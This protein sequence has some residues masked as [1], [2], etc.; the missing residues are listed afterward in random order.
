MP[1]NTRLG[2]RL[3][4]SFETPGSFIAAVSISSASVS[5][6]CDWSTLACG[7]A[8]HTS[9][10]KCEAE[11]R[12][13]PVTDSVNAPPI[14]RPFTMLGSLITRHLMSRRHRDQT[15]SAHRRDNR[16]KFVK[17]AGSRVAATRGHRGV[18][19][20]LT[21]WNSGDS[22]TP[23]LCDTAWRERTRSSSVSRSA[24]RDTLTPC[25]L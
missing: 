21:R 18:R 19:C 20:T 10:R 11:C 8:T 2:L 5:S 12:P 4:L 14:S 13:A 9:N 7:S 24:H 17:A 3:E 1:A 6:P 25:S 23:K 16:S 22:R 15:A